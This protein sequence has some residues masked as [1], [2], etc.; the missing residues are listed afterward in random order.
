MNKTRPLRSQPSHDEKT[1]AG[2]QQ[3]GRQQVIPRQNP[4]LSGCE[5]VGPRSEEAFLLRASL[6]VHWSSLSA[7]SSV[8]LWRAIRARLSLG[9]IV[10]CQRQPACDRP[11]PRL[12]A[13]SVRGGCMQGFRA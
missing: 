4:P 11:L 2:K 1:A 9:Y 12:A 13:A 10:R 5:R 8:N 6:K 7:S 3:G